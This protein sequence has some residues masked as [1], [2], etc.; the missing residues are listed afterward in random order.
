[1]PG[2]DN[3]QY[4][5]V[6]GLAQ[7]INF[8]Q[9]VQ[10]D[11]YLNAL[12]KSL[13]DENQVKIDTLTSMQ[14]TKYFGVPYIDHNLE[15]FYDKKSQE[16]GGIIGESG[17]PFQSIESMRK[18]KNIASEFTDNE[19]IREAERLKQ[20]T[21]LMDSDYAANK[22]NTQQYNEAKNGY[23]TYIQKNEDNPDI[24]KEKWMYQT[25]DQ[26]TQLEHAH[27][28]ADKYTQQRIENPN[29]GI[30]TTD[31]TTEQIA[32]MAMNIESDPEVAATFKLG[33][34][35]YLKQTSQSSG[36]SD[37]F[38]HYMGKYMRNLKPP[39]TTGKYAHLH[40][41]VDPNSLTGIPQS[42]YLQTQGPMQDNATLRKYADIDTK[43]NLIPQTRID[44]TGYTVLGSQGKPFMSIQLTN[45][46]GHLESMN[47]IDDSGL[48]DVGRGDVSYARN[49]VL[50]AYKTEYQKRLRQYDSKARGV[51]NNTTNPPINL[52]SESLASFKTQMGMDDDDL[53]DL[54]ISALTRDPKYVNAIEG[55]DVA[56]GEKLNSV[57]TDDLQITG[58]GDFAQAV[59]KV[60]DDP[61]TPLS[62]SDLT[63]NKNDLISLI[64]NSPNIEAL[65]SSG[66]QGSQISITGNA[67]LAY[68]LSKMNYYDGG[69]NFAAGFKTDINQMENGV[70]SP[71]DRRMVFKNHPIG[72]TFN[73]ANSIAYNTVSGTSTKNY[74][75]ATVA[76]Y[77]GLSVN[78]VIPMTHSKTLNTTFSMGA[79]TNPETKTKE[80]SSFVSGA[81]GKPQVM[82]AHQ[83]VNYAVQ[84][85]D[86]GEKGLFSDLKEL[87]HNTMTTNKGSKEAI[88]TGNAL[89]GM[90]ELY[91]NPDPVVKRF[92]DL[93]NKTSSKK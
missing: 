25:P 88:L 39:D 51:F 70:V 71:A 57:T 73:Q 47:S 23:L 85:Y 86:H 20:S 68:T 28:I 17:D 37:D 79:N 64:R 56:N 18:I 72:V 77:R 58:K 16:I 6:S 83:M 36:S 13:K 63:K 60:T 24:P 45:G 69:T 82:T 15:R 31:Y 90:T 29:T 26:Q 49:D 44:G 65:L 84:L 62:S 59:S 34:Q 42:T 35:N 10:R 76:L 11:Q 48:I 50:D 22:I 67:L 3:T 21:T 5:A 9:R 81:S 8:D 93:Y 30:T 38:L 27:D 7:T 4:G 87:W 1:M 89:S 80:I 40:P 52:N 14:K 74:D 53:K 19:W 2:Q 66:N 54:L 41:T 78:E 43:G 75:D 92:F 61:K 33:Y 46:L 32:Q 91:N 12:D 55:N